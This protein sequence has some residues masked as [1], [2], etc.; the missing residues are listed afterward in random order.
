MFDH[1]KELNFMVLFITNIL[2][3]LIELQSFLEAAT[4]FHGQLK[5]INGSNGEPLWN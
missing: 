3:W 1:I 2:Y 4:W 5:L